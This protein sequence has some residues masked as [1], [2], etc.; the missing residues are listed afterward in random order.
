MRFLSNKN[1]TL[2][3]LIA[4]VTFITYLPALNNDFVNWDDPTYV[5]ENPHLQ[6]LN[7]DFIEWAFSSVYFSNWHPL[8][9]I[10][11]ALDYS[12]WGLNPFGYHLTNIFFHACNTFLVFVLVVR[13]IECQPNSPIPL[14]NKEG[15]RGRYPSSLVAASV[16][17]LLFGIHPIH[18]ESVAWV[19]E[20]KDVL[21]AF[22][23]LL[24]LLVYLR[25][26]SA[27]TR[28]SLLYSLCL[29]LFA[30]ALLSKPMAVSFPVVLL[31]LDFYPLKRFRAGDEKIKRILAEKLPF[32]L[33]SLLSSLMTVWAQY[34]GGSLKPLEIY[35]L[36]TRFFVAMW[37]ILFYL[38]K[39]LIP[40]DLAPFYPYPSQIT[41][42]HIGAFILVSG[43]IAYCIKNR[44]LTAVWSYY[45]ITLI[46][47]IGIV[48]V[49]GF[50]A[51]DR[52]T[53]LP[54]IGPFMLAG[55]AISL[56]IEGYSRYK[57]AVVAVLAGL[58]VLTVSMTIKQIEVWRDSIT[59]WSHEIKIYP[60]FY[61]SYYSR[62]NAYI[63]LNR[64]DEVI[65]D[66]TKAIE[67]NPKYL[68]AYNNRGNIY[69]DLGNY[70]A[71]LSDY[72]K[73][74]ELNPLDSQVYTNRGNAYLGLG[75]YAQA[76]K[77][78]D[79]AIELNPNDATAYNNRGAAYFRSGNY[80]HAIRDF[81]RAVELD[82]QFT[83]AYNNLQA[84]DR[85]FKAIDR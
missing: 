18:V 38:S 2:P 76:I 9:M 23:F 24:A 74:L 29:L 44:L 15:V 4:L 33:F 60:D 5:Y 61:S 14:F 64:Y 78:H 22:F 28:T 10:S 83:D 82:P 72:N 56:L 41:A 31:I 36:T 7:L 32:F 62:G 34:L 20:R 79:R 77:N 69:F 3:F 45:I 40:L 52:Y 80:A 59:L 70:Q 49:A 30:M 16:T 35:P 8:T 66:Y 12:I 58:T 73:A 51:A 47:V 71:A 67:L 25:Y 39:M 68:D 54:S 11:Y 81:S 65:S 37:A 57:K 63:K 42:T 85:S 55:I 21:C 27:K 53:Y 17:A 84:A 43:L 75:D 1:L 13:L 6:L 19:S 48:Q 46:P 50:A 26:V